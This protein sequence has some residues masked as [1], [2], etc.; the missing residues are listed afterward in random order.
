MRGLE[1][2][3]PG[4][5]PCTAGRRPH[6]PGRGVCSDGEHDPAA[7]F[8]RTWTGVG[9]VS[10]YGAQI[11][12]LYLA[13][14]GTMLVVLH[15]DEFGKDPAAYDVRNDPAVLATLIEVLTR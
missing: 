9:G 11:N 6:H 13:V 3:V 8:E 14:R 4:H 15:F 12:H 7:A 1:E 5:L 2:L 10:A